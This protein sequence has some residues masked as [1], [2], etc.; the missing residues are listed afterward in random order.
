M[1]D[2]GG[3]RGRGG[4][5]MFAAGLMLAFI[6]LVFLFTHVLEQREN[7]NRLAV[8]SAQT[9]E[10]ELLSNINGQY[11]AEGWINGK[12]VT[13][14]LD[15]GATHIAVPAKLATAAGLVLQ[16]EETVSTAAGLATAWGTHIDSLR[17][18]P[19]LFSDLRGVVIPNMNGNTILLGMNALKQL[20]II[21]RDGKLILRADG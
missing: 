9:D 7:P 6:M 11:L 2:G 13:F 17:L 4:Y 18:G 16:R 1:N 10:L 5:W 19:F 14:L 21:Q 3:D 8:L 12:P 15:T 20:D